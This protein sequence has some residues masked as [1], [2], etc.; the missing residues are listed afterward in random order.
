MLCPLGPRWPPGP[1]SFLVA[2]AFKASGSDGVLGTSGTCQPSRPPDPAEVEVREAQQ[3]SSFPGPGPFLSENK[4]GRGRTSLASECSEVVPVQVIV[5][6]PKLSL[7]GQTLFR[8]FPMDQATPDARERPQLEPTTQDFTGLQLTGLTWTSVL[9]E[10][11]QC[12]GAH[13][14][15]R[16]P[17]CKNLLL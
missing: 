10:Y 5:L 1:L 8:D 17:S 3:A 4:N 14:H 11:S 15:M 16:Q 9:L 2:L 13:Y 6:S 12:Q 7:C